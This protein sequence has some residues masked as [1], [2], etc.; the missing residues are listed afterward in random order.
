MWRITASSVIAAVLAGIPNAV[1]GPAGAAPARTLDVTA[2]E[3][4]F[5]APD[6]MPAGVVTVRLVNRGRK[7][8]QLTIAR[9]DDTSS[10]DRVMR[11]LIANKVRTGGIRWV[12]GVES[13]IPGESGETTLPLASGRYVLV[14]AYDGD[15]GLAH[16]SLRRHKV[17][18]EIPGARELSRCHG[19]GPCR[20]AKMRRFG[21]HAGY[22]LEGRS[23]SLAQDQCNRAGACSSSL[24]G[25]KA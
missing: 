17:P 19:H 13:A 24:C 8:H 15:N 25:N 16:M 3:Y 14:C 20:A 4:S 7:A 12:G 1:Y 18:L 23:R 11:S 2:H 9:L 21:R 10:L 22:S 6:S 5:E